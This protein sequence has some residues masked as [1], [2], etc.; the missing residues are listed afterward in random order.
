MSANATGNVLAYSWPAHCKRYIEVLEAEDRFIKSSNKVESL[1]LHALTLVHRL[2]NLESW[3][4]C[5]GPAIMTPTISHKPRR[6]KTAPYL[7]CWRSGSC[8]RKP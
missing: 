2:R 3:R 5:P 8:Y 6:S 1:F 7:V 4:C